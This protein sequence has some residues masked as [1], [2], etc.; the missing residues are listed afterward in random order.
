[1]N[2]A[3]SAGFSS[4]ALEKYGSACSAKNGAA[5]TIQRLKPTDGTY[6]DGEG[7]T[8]QEAAKTDSSIVKVGDYYYRYLHPHGTCGNPNPPDDLH[9]AVN[10]AVGSLVPKLVMVK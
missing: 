4:E 6:V 10:E 2:E 9:Q 3:G 1:M 8:A 7:P 5:G